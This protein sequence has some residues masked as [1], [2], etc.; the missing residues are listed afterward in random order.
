MVRLS[1]STRQG[2]V[3]AVGAGAIL[4]LLYA[5]RGVLLPFG[6]ALF[7][8]YVTEPL[9]DRMERRQ[10]PR[11][12]AILVIYAVLVGVA[13]VAVV[14]F[15]PT[16]TWEAERAVSSL[17]ERLAEARKVAQRLVALGRNRR[18]P[19]LAVE[20][21]T[22]LTAELERAVAQVGRRAVTTTLSVFSHLALLLL[23]PVISFYLSRDLPALRQ[24]ILRLLPSDGRGELR[25]LLTEVNRVLGGYVRGQLVI[26]AFVGVTTWVGLAA[27]GIPYALLIGALAGLFDIVP[28]F[29]PVIG[30]VPA[31]VLALDRSPW[32][33]LYTVGLFLV[34]HQLEG[35]ILVPR[36]M[37][38]RVGLHPVLVIF[39]LLAGGQL[40]G[41]GGMLLAVP[42]A[43]VARVVL[44]FAFRRW[45][46]EE[47]PDSGASAGGDGIARG[48][49]END[50]PERVSP[51][52]SR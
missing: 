35:A 12:V 50:Q 29:G 43:A 42:A 47:Q 5:V 33:A 7:L 18:L 8:V 15:W 13:W 46:P 21:L 40:F 30:A 51:P 9:I 22:A 32:T 45:L 1:R 17:P 39:A 27:L 38:T 3:L 19:L 49:S 44:Q 16:I 14:Y 23:A 11:V 26:S 4:W 52:P 25:H 37:G 34:I 41:F 2:L 20:A 6:A 48:E 36:I 28:Y 24:G 10:V 31:V